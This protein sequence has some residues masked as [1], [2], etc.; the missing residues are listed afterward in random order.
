[1]VRDVEI[2]G[3]GSKK[4]EEKDAEAV[5]PGRHKDTF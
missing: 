2:E 3:R 4:K 5:A 1:M